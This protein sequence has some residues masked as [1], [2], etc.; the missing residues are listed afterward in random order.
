MP[1]EE[2]DVKEPVD[3]QDTPETKEEP[4]TPETKEEPAKETPLKET[5]ED[6]ESK[7]FFQKRH[8]ETLKELK[9]TRAT[10]QGYHDKL[11]EFEKTLPEK[12]PAATEDEFID[13]TTAEGYNR[14]ID[15]ISSRVSNASKRENLE[16]QKTSVSGKEASDAY[17][18]YSQWGDENKIP[19]EEYDAAI[20]VVREKL[21]PDTPP[22]TIAEFACQHLQLNAKEKARKELNKQI[23]EDTVIKTEA[24]KGVQ[25]PDAGATT[26]P[27]GGKVPQ[28]EDAI[29]KA[30]FKRAE[31]NA[32]DAMFGKDD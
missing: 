17:R 13:T 24:L 27:E 8:Q 14:M 3:K 25:E 7:A 6:L 22:S 9:E 12:K 32:N 10:A 28:T 19:K 18:S 20:V 29:V 30:K 16:L 23:A 4:K 31:A 2:K 21:H 1:D 11:V 5:A 26:T 15:D